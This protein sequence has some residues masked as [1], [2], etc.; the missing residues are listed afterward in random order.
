MTTHRASEDITSC[1]SSVF[2]GVTCI[3]DSP[4]IAKARLSPVVEECHAPGTTPH[5]QTEDSHSKI[6]MS[7]AEADCDIPSKYA[8]FGTLSQNLS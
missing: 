5:R 3:P 7:F 1:S 2:S 8:L 4:D 6:D